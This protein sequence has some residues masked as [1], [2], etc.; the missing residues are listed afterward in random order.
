MS[1][2]VNELIEINNRIRLVNKNSHGNNKSSRFG[3]QQEYSKQQN[4][5]PHPCR[6]S[7]EW[8]KNRKES[9]TKLHRNEPS[10]G[11]FFLFLVMRQRVKQMWAS[12]HGA[13]QTGTALWYSRSVSQPARQAGSDLSFEPPGSETLSWVPRPGT[14]SA[15]CSFWW[16][17]QHQRKTVCTR[18]TVF[19][20]A[21]SM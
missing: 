7:C 16:S 17:G 19:L 11:I 20:R 5:R 15:E 14:Q 1:S 6:V 13:S 18:N 4:P 12:L 10:P 9:F 21:A 2:L 3:N 8:M